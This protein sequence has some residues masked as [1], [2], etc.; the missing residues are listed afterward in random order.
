MA[1]K[2]GGADRS[3]HRKSVAMLNNE[4]IVKKSNFRPKD[5]NKIAVVLRHRG[6]SWDES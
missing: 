4:E 3:G 1:A 5:R 2:I 6:L